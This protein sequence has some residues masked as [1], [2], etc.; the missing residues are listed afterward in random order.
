MGR[1]LQWAKVHTWKINLTDKD[2]LVSRLLP[3][4]VL[5]YKS[6][7]P[8]GKLIALEQWRLKF[9]NHEYMHAALAVTGWTLV[10]AR[11]FAGVKYVSVYEDEKILKEYTGATV[12]R[13]PEVS[14]RQNVSSDLWDESFY[15][16]KKSYDWLSAGNR[17]RYVGN[18]IICSTLADL[19]LTELG[20][21]GEKHASPAFPQTYPAELFNKLLR[22]G[23]EDVGVFEATFDPERSPSLSSDVMPQILQQSED[24]K[25]FF[26]DFNKLHKIS[27]MSLGHWV[28]RTLQ[29]TAE[30]KLDS[31]ATMPLSQ[32]RAMAELPIWLLERTEE[33]ATKLNDQYE[34]KAGSWKSVEPLRLLTSELEDIFETH[35]TVV[36]ELM[37]QIKVALREALGKLADKS[38][39]RVDWFNLVQVYSFTVFT[40][41]IDKMESQFAPEP[42]LY[43]LGTSTVDVLEQPRF[44][45]RRKRL[46]N[47]ATAILHLLTALKKIPAEIEALKPETGPFRRNAWD[48]YQKF[49]KIA[50]ANLAEDPSIQMLKKMASA[51]SE[52]VEEFDDPDA[53]EA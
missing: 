30:E 37:A 6:K 18:R 27:A 47:E 22:H 29:M 40:Q 45:E 44:K 46:E 23:F 31:F 19:I 43:Q 33:I 10:E 26:A 52:V 12:L 15:H 1:L 48:H 9:A 8:H 34:I 2:A 49:M 21:L 20:I 28:E 25:L 14:R 42:E 32:G 5:F 16:Y 53:G 11:T 35:L 39:S 38:L 13:N 3:G 51:L 41:D 50:E 4:D 24:L 7:K 17:K 36:L